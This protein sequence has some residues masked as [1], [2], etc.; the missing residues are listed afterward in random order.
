MA[1]HMVCS[2]WLVCGWM[3]SLVVGMGV[4]IYQRQMEPRPETSRLTPLEWS[5]PSLPGAKWDGG[6][7]RYAEIHGRI[8]EE[9]VQIAR[10]DGQ[11][12]ASTWRG[13]DHSGWSYI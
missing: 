12:I 11:G 1:L 3:L 4:A 10:V 9:R 6:W 2:H 5:F 13:D 7:A 8:D